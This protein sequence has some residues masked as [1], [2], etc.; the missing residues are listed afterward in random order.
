MPHL[1]PV[2]VGRYDV[3]G[4]AGPWNVDGSDGGAVL[5]YVETKD[6]IVW[7]YADGA[8]Q[9]FNGRDANGAVYGRSVIIRR[10]EAAAPTKPIHIGSDGQIME[11]PDI[12]GVP[13][14]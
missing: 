6:W 9:V 4:Q 3:E 5:G 7:M 1:E 10:Q 13:L 11:G 2:T 8:V 12:A 14:P